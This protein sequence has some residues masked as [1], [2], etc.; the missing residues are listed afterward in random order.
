M[1][2]PEE[3]KK[4]LSVLMIDTM[5]IYWSMKNVNEKDINILSKWDLKPK[6][7]ILH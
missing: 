7:P 6:P 5:G 3:V 1:D 4:N 2:L